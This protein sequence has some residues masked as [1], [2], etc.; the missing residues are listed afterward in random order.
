MTELPTSSAPP[1]YI[2]PP[3]GL[4]ML[5]ALTL[6]FLLALLLALLW[7]LW[8]RR[9]RRRPAPAPAQKQA[10][11][12]PAPA[13]SLSSAITELQKRTLRSKTFRDGCHA[14]AVLV[15]KH[16]EQ[17]TGL[18]VEEM[19]SRELQKTFAG[20][21]RGDGRIDGERLGKFMTDLSARRYGREEPRTRDFV[22]ACDAARSL[23]TDDSARNA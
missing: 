3:T 6:A 2:L 20:G 8:K 13:A 10:A 17:I 19:T 21:V 9:Q 15:K 11:A 23:L 5:A 16:L 22:V 7:R 4:M 12:P 18:G 14:L 1:L